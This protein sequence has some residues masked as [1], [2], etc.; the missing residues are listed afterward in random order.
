VGSVN[1]PSGARYINEH[2][3]LISERAKSALLAKKA[4]VLKKA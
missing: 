1:T 3:R 4:E 2:R